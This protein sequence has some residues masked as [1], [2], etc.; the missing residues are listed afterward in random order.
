MNVSAIA[1]RDLLPDIHQVTD[2]IGEALRDLL[3]EAER[4]RA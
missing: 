3:K 4:I 1:C 2:G